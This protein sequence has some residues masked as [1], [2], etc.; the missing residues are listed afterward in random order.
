MIGIIKRSQEKASKFIIQTDQFVYGNYMNVCATCKQQFYNT[1]K[2]WFLCPTHSVFE[3]PIVETQADYGKENL[4][5]TVIFNAIRGY[6]D[7]I[8]RYYKWP[9]GMVIPEYMKDWW[10]KAECKIAFIDM[11]QTLSSEAI[12]YHHVV[13]YRKC[14]S[15]GYNGNDMDFQ[16]K[17]TPG[18]VT[19]SFFV[20]TN[21]PECDS[22]DLSPC[23]WDKELTK[24]YKPPK[25]YTP[26]ND[27]P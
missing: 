5:K 20:T 23:Y 21:C 15:C 1:N 16:M 22:V 14:N 10:E 18:G 17:K 8:G 9:D 6:K 13:M 12:N 25:A 11:T 4:D 27:K 2:M 26:P 24:E 19:G 7:M 3:F